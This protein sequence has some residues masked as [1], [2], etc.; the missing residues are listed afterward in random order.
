MKPQ[1]F[2]TILLFALAYHTACQPRQK[3]QRS[4]T[5]KKVGGPCEECEAA[6]EFGSRQLVN[7][8]TLPDFHEKGQKLKIFG[9]VYQKDG[10]TPAA[11]VIVYAYHT[12]Q[13][14][15]YSKKGGETGWGLRHGYI[16]GWIK[17]GSDGKYEFY[18]LR[19]V[20][21]P[22]RKAPEHIHVTIKEP[23]LTAYYIDEFLFDD[24]KLLGADARARQ[25]RR[26]G[27]G[28]LK[29]TMGTDGIVYAHHDI[30]LGMNIPDYEQ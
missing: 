27:D 5:D 21:Y 9:I 1:I 4:A 10:K 29:L 8:D 2:R 13:T 12:D 22:E 26:G 17:T 3:N 28:I 16:R 23:G 24:D 15:H 14:G 11:D 20:A 7:V 19:P 18:T 6:L 25:L 30:I